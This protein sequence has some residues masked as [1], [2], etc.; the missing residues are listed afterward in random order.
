[1]ILE[2]VL[3]NFKKEDDGMDII[4]TITSHTLVYNRHGSIYHINSSLQCDVLPW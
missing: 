2:K 1:M 4:A 3:C